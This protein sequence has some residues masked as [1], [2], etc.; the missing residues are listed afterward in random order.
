MAEE[1]D[2]FKIAQKQ[3]MDAA[4]IM[5]LDKDAL[6]I[7][8]EPMKTVILNIPIRMDSGK[9]KNFT[10]F[11]VH[12]N[13]ARGPCKGGI[14]YHPQENLS[15]VKALS[16]WM[17]WKSALAN[18]PFGGA[19]G[20]VICDPKA[21]SLKEIEALSRGYIRALMCEIGPETDIP[22]PDVNTTPQIMGWMMDEYSKMAGKDVFST[23]TGKPVEIWGSLGRSDSTAVGGMVILREA[24]KTMKIN[25]KTAKIAVQGF[26]NVG[27]NAA[28]VAREMFGSKIVAVSDSNGGIFDK[29]GLDVKKVVDTKARYGSVQA[30]RGVTKITNQELLEQDVDIL[31]PAA[32]ENQIRGDNAAKINAKIVLELANGPVTPDGDRVLHERGILDL[33]DFMVNGGGV[34][35][36]YFEWVQNINGYYWSLEEV[37]KRLDTVMTNSYNDMM[38]MRKAYKSKGTEIT[39]RTAAYIV[40]VDRVAKAMKARGWY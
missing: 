34:L 35:V 1:L 13:N 26:G 20:G 30:L 12:Y 31:I 10:G 18:I 7:L 16:A 4:S 27:L 22:A 39:P 36:S 25:L 24:A 28:L 9:I 14:R 2:P 29:K 3:L 38:Q 11:R 40:A 17:T 15:V 23:I 5:E 6:E 37:E 8:K 21:M 19:K 33:P 32:M